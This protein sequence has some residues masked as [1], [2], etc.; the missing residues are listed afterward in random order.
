MKP[1]AETQVLAD[2]K[3]WKQ[4]GVLKNIAQAS[5]FWRQVYALFR[6]EA[7][8]AVTE[9]LPCIGRF[10]P[11][12]TIDKACFSGTGR[13]KDDSNAALRKRKCKLQF[14][15]AVFFMDIY[16]QHGLS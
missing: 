10:Q 15:L 5:A 13:A 1:E 3:V 14:E 2:R 6:V 7:G 12:N 9:Y 8:D 11:C 4:A 16:V